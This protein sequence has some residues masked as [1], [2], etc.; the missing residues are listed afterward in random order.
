VSW[1]K[2]AHDKMTGVGTINVEVS[3]FATRF[4]VISAYDFHRHG[5]HTGKY[6]RVTLEI[7]VHSMLKLRVLTCSDILTYLLTTVDSHIHHVTT[8]WNSS[9]YKAMS[10]QKNPSLP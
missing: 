10:G 4:V 9:L 6:S 3:D 7:C 2:V 5:F 8:Q 1:I